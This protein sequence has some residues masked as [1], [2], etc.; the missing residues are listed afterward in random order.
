M[1]RDLGAMNYSRS[2]PVS[3][4]VHWSSSPGFGRM[5]HPTPP[6]GIFGRFETSYGRGGSYAGD[7]GNFEATPTGRR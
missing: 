2:V 5:E 6:S 3:P 7:A 1:M 4:A